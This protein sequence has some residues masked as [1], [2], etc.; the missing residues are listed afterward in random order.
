MI[1]YAV[2]VNLIEGIWSATI[3]EKYDSL[4]S[5]MQ[6]QSYITKYTS[7]FSIIIALMGNKI[8]QQFR[9]LRSALLTPIVIMICGSIFFT[10]VYIKDYI[11]EIVSLISYISPISLIL[12][13]GGLQNILG[14][15]VKYSIFDTTKEMAY[16]PLE[17][18]IKTKGKAAVDIVATT[19]GKSLGSI[20]QFIIFT[21]LPNAVYQ[22]VS[23]LLLII[24][25][26]VCIIWI[27]SVR[28]LNCYYNKLILK[29]N[30]VISGRKEY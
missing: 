1:S 21:I 4:E 9:W 8:I 28:K 24:F 19:F 11:S 25:L 27:Y 16:I 14:K 23:L 6:Y 17:R 30:F 15:G 3:R 2:S 18:E 29:N 22:D 7:I 12:F 10:T 26:F 5:F 20:I 13:T